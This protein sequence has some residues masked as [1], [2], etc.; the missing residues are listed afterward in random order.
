VAG[1]TIACEHIIQGSI[2]VMPVCLVTG[3]AAG[4]AARLAT[5]KEDMDVRE[6]DIRDLR[7]ILQRNGAFL[8]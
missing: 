6:I 1:R 5:M 2:R 8:E 3:Q 4:T 7:E